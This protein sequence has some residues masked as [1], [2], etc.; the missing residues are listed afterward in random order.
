M[1]GGR[2]DNTAPFVGVLSD[3]D[4]IASL[5]INGERAPSVGFAFNRLDI[6]KT[7]VPEPNLS[8]PSAI[9]FGGFLGVKLLLKRKPMH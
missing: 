6:V 7:H 4:N 3:S 2:G 1:Y 8:L 9:A 5:R